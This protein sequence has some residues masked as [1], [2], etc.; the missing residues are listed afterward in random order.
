[1][2][3]KIRIAMAGV[4]NCASN[5]VQGI[6][7]YKKNVNSSAGLLYR[8]AGGYDVTD[9]EVVA[10]FDI[11]NN[12]VGK[13]L[14]EAIKAKPN[15]TRNVAEVPETGVIVQKGP[16]LD[17]WGPHME[18]A[19]KVSG[20][21]ECDAGAVL[22]LSRPDIMVIALPTGSKEACYYYIGQALKRGIS[23]VNGIPV[24]A[25]H[26]ETVARLAVK[27]KCAIIGDDFKSQ[28][29][30]TVLHNALLRLLDARGIKINGSHHVNYAGN[31][32][33][34]NL[35]TRGEEKHKSKAR[36]IKAGVS[37]DVDLSVNITYLE[38]QGDNKTCRV[39][40]EGEN[41]SGCPVTVESKLTVVDSANA[42]GVLVDAA[43]CL[44]VAKRKGIYGRLEAVSAYFCKSPYKQIP[45]DEARKAVVKFLNG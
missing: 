29:G 20:A 11:A 42:S 33:F 16:V 31:A 4:G 24:L 18:K 36:G 43:R 9:I 30:G 44:M 40:I 19:V 23:V 17:G 8:F 25:S 28:I 21:P 38:N 14:S 2:K 5:L 7:Y 3:N 10:A 41:F 15:C 22:D 27:N 26:D 12:K 6:E 37:Q 39:W 13:D 35:Y 45:E 32:D 1:M 34:L